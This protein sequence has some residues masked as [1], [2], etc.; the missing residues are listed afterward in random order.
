MSEQN[1][2]QSDIQAGVWLEV[3][4]QARWSVYSR[5]QVLGIDCN[6]QSGQPLRVQVN[7]VYDLVQCWSVSRHSNWEVDT[8]PLLRQWL[9]QCWAVE[10]AL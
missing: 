9:A 5:L 3:T 10:V 8:K 6:C 2:P 1:P 4:G 7:S